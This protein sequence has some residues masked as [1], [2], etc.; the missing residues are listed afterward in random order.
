MTEVLIWHPVPPGMKMRPDHMIAD[1]SLGRYYIGP[2]KSDGYWEFD[3]DGLEGGWV[4]CCNF[5]F[6]DEVMQIVQGIHD[7]RLAG[8]DLESLTNALPV[9]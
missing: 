6:K 7:A 5:W 9:D 4:G 3:A 2:R 8:A 1:T